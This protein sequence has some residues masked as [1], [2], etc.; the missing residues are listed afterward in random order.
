VLP[1]VFLFAINDTTL[2]PTLFPIMV[3]LFMGL[4]FVWYYSLGT[5]LHKKLPASVSMHIAWFRMALFIPLAHLLFVTVFL[6]GMF[7]YIYS[8][9]RP[10]APFITALIF[11]L[12]LLS[13]YCILYCLYFN[14]KALKAAEWQRPVAFKDFA[15]ELFLFC[16]FSIGVWIL[17]PRI[18]KLFERNPGFAG[19]N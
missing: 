10:G 13:V 17:Q 18:N 3:V 9:G 2:M 11:P 6:Y 12:D 4:C 14:A 8:G 15:G 1:V 19:P 7:P 16:F 5:N